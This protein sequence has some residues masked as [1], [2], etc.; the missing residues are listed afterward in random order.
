MNHLAGIA[1]RAVAT[2][3][4]TAISRTRDYE[5]LSAN[6]RQR[7]Q[8]ATGIAAR[9]I[10]PA[11]QCAS[12][13]CAVAAERVIDHLGWER[14]SIGAVVLITQT[15]DQPI[16]ATAIVLQ[17]KLGLPKNCVAFDVNLG[18]SSYP[19]G[20]AILGA[21][22]SSL[23]IGRALLLM[24]DVSSRVCAVHDKSAWPL[25]GDAGSAT[26]LELSADASPM[27]FDLMSDGS[28]KNA[29]IVPSGGLA[30]RRPLTGE[31]IVEE[32]GADGI[33]RRSDNLVL[34]GTDVFSFAITKVPP[35]VD[36]VVK[37]AGKTPAEVDFLILHQAN[38]MINDTIAKKTGFPVGKALSTLADY[39]N[40]SSASIPLTFCAHAELFAQDRHVVV[41]GFGVGL[42]WGSTAFSLRGGA[43]LPVVE[44]DRVY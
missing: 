38:K 21:M 17:H 22:M 33:S 15:A 41:C 18:C 7:L 28:G 29:I 12:D 8:A 34:R 26:A 31:R 23:G 16:P 30:S 2:A 43:I 35:S 13:L 6:D 9:R 42:S 32:A 39:G 5:Y 11:E 40:T 10:S 44:S 37:A 36:R 24:G 4:P 27:H 14:D 19:F 20:L 3:V 25:F 1:I